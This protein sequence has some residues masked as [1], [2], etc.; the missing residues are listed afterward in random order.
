MSVFQTLIRLCH[1][2]LRYLLFGLEF[3]KK[4]LLNGV[5][6]FLLWTWYKSPGS[7]RFHQ[8]VI[9][10]TLNC[11]NEFMNNLSRSLN[12][13][14][15]CLLDKSDVIIA[16]VAIVSR[17]ATDIEAALQKIPESR[18][19]VLVVL[20]H[21]FDTHFVAP[22]SRQNV[23][24]SNVFT[25]DCLFH[26]DRGLLNCG[27]N[28][29]AL[30]ETA[31]HLSAF[32]WDIAKRNTV[33]LQ[34]LSG[35]KSVKMLGGSRVVNFFMMV[36]GNTLY[37]NIHFIDR[38]TTR[39]ELH[40]VTDLEK[41]HSV[42]AFVV[43]ASR[44]G[45]D[46]EAALRKIPQ[47]SRPTV[48]VVLHHTFDPNFIAPDSRQ[49]VNRPGVFTV[50]CLFH[51]D[52]GLLRCLR[53]DEALKAV[54]DHLISKGGL[55]KSHEGFH[56]PLLM[57]HPAVNQC[58]SR[59]TRNLWIVIGLLVGA[60]FGVLLGLC[61]H[62]GQ[63][64]LGAPIGALTAYL[65][66]FRLS[67]GKQSTASLIDGQLTP[68]AQ[69]GGACLK[70]GGGKTTQSQRS[71]NQPDCWSS[72]DN[73][74]AGPHLRKYFM[75]AEGKLFN[76]H[77]KFLE[78]LTP[79]LQLCEVSSEEKSDV[80]IAFLAVVSRA[81][82]DIEA[83][84]NR[85]PQTTRPVVLVVLH[86]TFDCYFVAPDSKLGVTRTDVFA[87]DCLFHE[88]QGLLRCEHNDQALKAVT[89]HLISKGASLAP[90]SSPWNLH[91][92]RVFSLM[93]VSAEGERSTVLTSWNLLCLTHQPGTDVCPQQQS[94]RVTPQPRES[95]TPAQPQEERHRRE[96]LASVRVEK[97]RR[98]QREA[99]QS[100]TAEARSTTC[101]QACE[102]FSRFYKRFCSPRSSQTTAPA[103]V[104]GAC[105]TRPERSRTQPN[106]RSPSVNMPAES[107]VVKFY[108]RV[109]GN[110]LYSD[111]NFMER[112]T[113]RLHLVRASS[114]EDGDLIIAFVC[115][116]S[117]AGTDIHDAVQRIP[118]TTRPVVL[119]V[120]HH[121]FDPYFVAP[122]SNLGVTRTD[123]FIVDC[124][125]HEDQG[126]LRCEHNDQAL[127]AVTDHLISKGASP[128]P[129]APVRKTPLYVWIVTGCV[130]V[131]I[132]ALAVYLG[133]HF[134][135]LHKPHE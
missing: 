42:I 129:L 49:C 43:I 80:I 123:M 131:G 35:P 99:R 88:D 56:L 39:L 44:A 90:S 17:A 79:G 100:R 98:S 14:Q 84:L 55:P 48:L 66:H 10:N 85:I 91:P 63:I 133:V 46:L 65:L 1:C 50:D 15:E 41:S 24:R 57:H 108:M 122:D 11:H 69:E 33:R 67:Y 25:V 75:R 74:S 34:K 115:I 76:S 97:G 111:M 71:R 58:C 28:T 132:T 119:V 4:K 109:F 106:C 114:E 126:L 37:S 95:P 30:K 64:F 125:F 93:E 9:G 128:A 13:H 96:G 53:N 87:V 135:E 60:A 92:T 16:F 70:T 103:Q 134:S 51:E 54:A 27:H 107:H 20:H 62:T 38:L 21:T 121:T 40:E 102:P 19:V 117:R 26:E 77:I 82:T 124:L 89:D 31:E 8:M 78:R 83:A 36:F 18:P 72:P 68:L 86:H 7:I 94:V 104:G 112:L 110:T 3:V 22:D 47:T 127:K 61:D 116:A 59:K 113:E 105:V 120:L 73:M 23:T 130:V 52:Q 12:L 101:L 32:K 118:E 45:T 2:V 6:R 29:E 81:G 5:W